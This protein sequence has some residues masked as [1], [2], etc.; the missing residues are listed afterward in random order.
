MALGVPDL[1]AAREFCEK[2]WQLDLVDTGSDRVFLG[3][4]CQENQVLRLRATAEPRV[5]LLCLAAAHDADV[6]AI[7]GRVAAH[8]LGRLVRARHLR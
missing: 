1:A 8:P 6:Y 7:A 3:A 2:H 4:G 5:D